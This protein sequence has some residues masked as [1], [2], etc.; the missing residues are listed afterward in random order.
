[1]NV[2]FL[3]TSVIIVICL[4]GY[5]QSMGQSFQSYKKAADKALLVKDYNAALLYLNQALQI[6]QNDVNLQYQYAEVARRFN[7]FEIAE[8][9][10]QKVL[11]SKE[12]LA[13]PAAYFGLALV[14]KQIGKYEEAIDNFSKFMAAKAVNKDKN[15]LNRSKEEIKNCRWAIKFQYRI[16][17]KLHT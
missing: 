14:K 2:S 12:K 16:L 9:Y 6:D 8:E 15:K 3:K 5:Y 17:L 7:A 10:Y 4:L 13:Y 1:M 11:D